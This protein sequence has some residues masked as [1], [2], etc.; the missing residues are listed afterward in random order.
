MST[1][2]IVIIGGGLAGLSC[3]WE[4]EQNSVEAVLLESQDDVG[5]RVRSDVVD[6]FRLD[7]GFQALQ[8][9]Y[10]EARRQLD[11]A[12]LGLHAFQ[13][14]AL[15]RTEAGTVRMSDPWR[16]P[17]DIFST[18]MNG[19]GT[20][21]DRFRLARLRW[22]VTRR[23]V[24][25]LWRE[26]DLTTAAYLKDHCGFSADMIT[27][28]FRPWFAGVFLEDKLETSSRFFKFI[29]RMFAV[30]DVAL[31]KAGM[32]AI[33]RQLADRLTATSIRLN[34]RVE[35]IDG[36]RVCLE[37]K[38]IIESRGVVLAV[39]GLEAS[40]LTNRRIHPPGFNATTCLYYAAQEPPFREKLL[41]LNGDQSPPINNLCVPSNV[42]S[43]YAPDGQAL[44][45]VSV[46][47]QTDT[48]S[49][50]VAI[51]V[52]RQLRDWFGSQVDQ[53]A[54]LQTCIIRNALPFRPVQHSEATVSA[55]K[56]A[57]GFYR[58]GDYCETASIQGAMLSGR[59]AA[60]AIVLDLRK[61]G[62]LCIPEKQE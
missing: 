47:G 61:S 46:I 40:R 55:C 58:C 10:P 16:R 1:K 56:I 17:Q 33:P 25:D 51:A 2:P 54:L 50:D 18:L 8:T 42:V 27:R 34:T 13:P 9:A 24:E 53:W 37:N 14:G 12:A 29:F 48:P 5:G 7:R 11:Y 23:T 57:D 35:S 52:R 30:G 44:V 31:P 38:E 43:G 45:S 49:A 26:P 3:A 32:G 4:L 22:H 6:G 21:A 39:D 59:K 15:I 41:M 28:F 60:E 19:V 20:L 36:L 62:S